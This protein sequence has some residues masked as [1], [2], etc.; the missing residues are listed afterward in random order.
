MIIIYPVMHEALKPSELTEHVKAVFGIDVGKNQANSFIKKYKNEIQGRKTKL[1]ASKR[2]DTTIS[3]HVIEFIGQVETVAQFYVMNASNV[4]NYDET[5]VFL[6]DDRIIR[7]EHIKKERAQKWGFK[8]RTIG[9]L[10]SFVAANGL[11]LMSVWIFK[12]TKTKEENNDNLL[13]AQ[14]HI[15][16][17]TRLLCGNWKQFYTFTGSGYSNKQVHAQ[18]MEEF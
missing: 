18:I 3:E 4:C 13:E 10:V 6:T 1:L 14:F 8:G 11:V 17:Q 7:L 9:S 15:E 2:V 5:R 12:A 16:P